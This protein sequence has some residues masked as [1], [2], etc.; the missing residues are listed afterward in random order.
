MTE[1]EASEE[2]EE[3]NGKPMNPNLH[4]WFSK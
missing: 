2:K 3:E 4:F 1:E